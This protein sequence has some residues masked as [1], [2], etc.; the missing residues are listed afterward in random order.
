MKVL[1][2]LSD[3]KKNETIN[4]TLLTTL[5]IILIATSSCSQTQNET[6][7]N[8]GTT[9]VTVTLQPVRNLYSIIGKSL[10]FSMFLKIKNQGSHTLSTTDLYYEITGY[11][12]DIIKQLTGLNNP[13]ETLYGKN[14]FNTDG[15]YIE[16]VVDGKTE[17]EDV[18]VDFDYNVN[19][20]LRYCYKYKTKAMANV[21]LNTDAQ[22]Y[23]TG[24]VPQTVSLSGGQGAPIEFLSVTPIRS[25]EG[26]AF[27]IVLRN[28]G[29]GAVF[30]QNTEIEKCTS[31]SALSPDYGKL[32]IKAY[33][34]NT[35]S[36]DCSPME[37]NIGSGIV[38]IRCNFQG[39]AGQFSRFLN[40]EADYVYADF[41][42]VPLTF[43]FFK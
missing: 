15:T 31:L 3:F 19:F 38:T 24:C 9:G 2:K 26:Y 41:S 36:G 22:N 39:Q 10:D 42:S 25:S 23:G 28:S 30:S 20:L 21:C 33:F 35:E 16:Y 6:Q 1:K 37:P 18:L 17:F 14:D 4:T 27:E 32:S 13:A 34:D 5:L 7:G 12:K 29:N 11:D 40:L 8:F 43:R